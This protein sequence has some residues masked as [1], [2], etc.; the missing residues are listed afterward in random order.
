MP[1]QEEQP[2]ALEH[3]ILTKFW[4]WLG[5][6]NKNKKALSAAMIPTA[7]FIPGCCL[8]YL[9][10]LFA[11]RGARCPAL[12]PFFSSFGLA[13][14]PSVL[15]LL[16]SWLRFRRYMFNGLGCSRRLFCGFVTIVNSLLDGIIPQFALLSRRVPELAHKARPQNGAKVK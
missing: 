14:L 11:A 9:P 13:N 2:H 15:L 1:A 8:F 12:A 4:F 10:A 16:Y 6:K 5:D 7:L 3:H